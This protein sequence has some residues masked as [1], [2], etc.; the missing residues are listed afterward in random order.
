[1]VWNPA[2]AFNELPLLPPDVDLES[3]KVLKEAIKA[4]A[5]LAELSAA[6]S[7]LPNPYVLVNSITLLEAQAS[8]EIENIVTTTDDL[9]SFM[10]EP[11]EADD[12]AVREA[13]RYRRALFEG[14]QYLKTHP[15]TSNLAQTMC[16]RIKGIEM[17]FRTMPG[18]FIG[19]PASG[20]AVYTPPIGRGVLQPLLD[21]WE[22]FT[23]SPGELDPLI[24]MA[25]SHYQFEAIHPFTDGNGRTGRLI[26]VL[27][28]VQYGLIAEPVLYLSKYIIE[29]KSEYY[30]RLLAVTSEGDWES[31]IIFMLRGIHETSKS[32]LNKISGIREVFAKYSLDF[33]D[34]LPGTGSKLEVVEVVFDKPYCRI[35]DVMEKCD[36]SRQTASMWL[37][38]LVEEGILEK[39]KIGRQV[40]Y[41]NVRFMEILRA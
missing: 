1:M 30:K 36:V 14:F 39:Y 17:D 16:S 29:N 34:I 35:S 27:C 2:R 9:F 26:N 21:N 31:W 38:T 19:N 32:T 11:T 8:S 23:N 7:T 15:I 24:S 41:I 20:E 5:A 33:K 10:E 3:K 22:E 6:I 25:V 37:K 4:R 13:L 40:L 28:L 18:T 12:P